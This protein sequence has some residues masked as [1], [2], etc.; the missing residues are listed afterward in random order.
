MDSVLAR[1]L[2]LAG[3]G[4]AGRAFLR[5]W[6][7]AGGRI[8]QVIGR[9][10][11]RFE[12]P[13]GAFRSWDEARLEDSDLLVLAVPDDAISACAETLAPRIRS[14]FAFHLS[15]ALSADVLAPLRTSG[16]SVASLHPLRPFTGAPGE[17][18]NGAF[19]AVEG[20]PEAALVGERIATA[21]HAR[22]HRLSAESKPLYHA[23]A[24]LAAGG[25]VAVLS[26]A[27]RA[28]VAAGIPEELSR[29]GLASLAARAIAAAARGSFEQAFT[30]AVA[31]RD[32]GTVR[33]HARALAPYADALDLYRALAEEILAE[34]P[35]RPRGRDPGD[36]RR[37]GVDATRTRSRLRVTLSR[38]YNSPVP[39][40][41]L[42][43]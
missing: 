5:S 21:L 30:G 31:R 20:E 29:E 14:A 11:A 34:T 28:C 36:S 37:G 9:D 3:P 22:P 32:V 4:R 15:G 23:A 39:R 25:T 13:T 2:T 35:A 41:L 1:S 10:A 33:S 8:G 43:D 40:F 7:D 18:W 16:A 27:V 24:S 17:D 6:T 19:V 26:V 42:A 38:C 12:F